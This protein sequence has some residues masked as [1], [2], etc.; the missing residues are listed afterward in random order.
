MVGWRTEP[1]PDAEA[2]LADVGRRY[3]VACL[4]NLNPMQWPT[5]RNRLGLGKWFQHQF[6]S[7]EIGLLKPD[8]AI[9]EHV[10]KVLRV[11]PENIIFFDDSQA[12]VDGALQAGWSA[13][14]VQ[15][16]HELKAKLSELGL[17]DRP[18]R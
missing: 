4:C 8:R 3:T 10:S 17:C 18:G 16:T 13:H 5:I 7:C 14:L 2:V 9:Y 1:Y 15:G 12:N 6:V 11:V